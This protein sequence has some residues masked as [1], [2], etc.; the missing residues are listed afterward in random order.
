[1]TKCAIYCRIS[2]DRIGAGLGVERQVQDCRELAARLG[3]TVAEVFIDND[4][5]ASGKK[6]RPEYDRM[7]ADIAAGRVD[8]VLAWHTDRLHRKPAELEEYIT[9]CD[10]RGIPTYTVKAGALD[11]TTPSG[12]LVARQLG[13][14][15]K[16]ESEHAAERQQR[17]KLETAAAGEW[18]GGRR[19]Y[20]FDADGITIRSDEACIVAE[21]TD[22][23][24]LGSSLRGRSARLNAAG[25]VTTTGRPF[26]P[27]ALRRI[28]IRPRNAG[29]REHRGQIV[30]KA[31]WPAIV[32]EEKWRAVAALLTDPARRTNAGR[33][34]RWLLSGVARCWACDEPVIV[35]RA[36]APRRPTPS[37]TC[38][39]GK[40]VVRNAAEL[41]A[42]VCMVM[43]AGLNRPGWAELTRPAAPEIDLAALN[44]EEIELQQRLD[45][46]A[47]DITLKERVLA[48]RTQALEKRLAE[49]TEQKAAAG[50]GWALSGVADAPD[51]GAAF[52]R[53]DLDRKRAIIQLLLTITINR[54]PKGRPAGWR[55]GESYFDP[56]SVTITKRDA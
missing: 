41:D 24:L 44:A 25:H 9:A 3:L 26:T 37:Y 1:M 54:A 45:A 52:D 18:A 19:P 31:A 21:E 7:L 46:L 5:S 55:A 49:I 40:H 56:D 48:R 17:K 28:L 12:R 22:A 15:A 4:I 43:R 35:T 53:L 47:D 36:S 2:R 33:S 10:A 38:R 29:L 39:A 27:S 8:A 50:R 14:V 34:P 11:L 13:A 6:K 42:Y 30:G 51:P 23:I 32:A 20:G 16:F